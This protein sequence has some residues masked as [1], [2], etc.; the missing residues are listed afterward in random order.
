MSSA[1]TVLFALASLA[2]A[3]QAQ[4][5]DSNDTW[6]GAVAGELV[7]D[8]SDAAAAA[9]SPVEAAPAR[10]AEEASATATSGSRRRGPLGPEKM[11]E[12]LIT[13]ARKRNEAVQNTPVAVTSFSVDGLNSRDVRR[14]SDIDGLVPN[15]QIDNSFGAAQAGRLTIRGV[16]QIE[17]TTSFDPAVGVYVDGAYVSRAQGQIGSLF[18]I[19]RIEVLRGPQGTLYGKNTIGGAVNITTRKPE[20]DF[21]GSGTVR[22]GNFGRFDTRFTLNVP[23]VAERAALRVAL[24]SNYDDG[25]EKNSFLDERLATDRLLGTRAELLVLPS[26]DVEVMLTGEYT[27]EDRRPQAA[28]CVVTG[29]PTAAVQLATGQILRA[30]ARAT[31]LASQAQSERR[32]TSEIPADDD[33]RVAHVTNTINWEIGDSTMFKSITSYRNQHYDVQQDLDGTE[34]GIAQSEPDRGTIVSDAWSQE[35]QLSGRFAG[36]R[37]FYVLGLF[38]FGEKIDDD[39]PGGGSLLSPEVQKR[40][41]QGVPF[42][43]LVLPLL[44]ETRDVENRSYA[45]YGSLT[46]A[47]T[48]RLSATVGLRRTVERRRLKKRD[49]T[50][51]GGF[52]P[53]AANFTVTGDT[54][55][56]FDSAARFDDFSPNASLSFMVNPRVMTYASYATG[57][58]SGGFN[59]R[60]N[61]INPDL[62]EIEPEDLQTFEVGFKSSFFD[63]RLIVNAA[64]YYSIFEDIQ[65][66]IFDAG[67]AGL[68][69][70]FFENAA[71][72]RLYGGEIEVAALPLPG[73]RLETSIGTFRGRY[74]DFDEP[75]LADPTLVRSNIEDARLPGQP[76][77]VMSFAAGYQLPIFVGLLS[78][79]VQWT[80]RGQQANDVRDTDAFRSSKYGLLDARLSL[81]LNDGK[82]ELTFFGSNLL[83]REYINNGIDATIPAGR[84]I[85]FFGPPR[86]YG[87]ELKRDF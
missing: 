77:Y 85:V 30:D 55:L 48:Q 18:D 50:L 70:I 9:D 42:D 46:Y 65:R 66:P 69:A 62:D 76:N 19:E 28:R 7:A 75:A 61:F 6:F 39:T 10:A 38:A 17:T 15:L 47:I 45:G 71:E 60:L 64:G 81:A 33:F 79:R 3:G 87:L 54:V 32:F 78:S 31:C 13:T 57:F 2:I 22:V 35:L 26:P 21:G 82:T 12:E 36:D 72:A 67:P 23:L 56:F 80:H 43:G 4:A 37:L 1:R 29:E 73:L 14:L 84:G 52:N 44:E 51:L 59:G 34:L 24:A 5:E 20:F 53:A 8:A 63:S 58:R 16:G 41:M 27:R 11:I 83:D 74:T 49:V 25:Y 86:R 68:L 40:S